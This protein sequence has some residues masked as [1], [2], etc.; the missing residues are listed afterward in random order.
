MRKRVC[1]VAK[2]PR[3]GRVK[4]RLCPPLAPQ[5]AAALASAFLVDTWASATADGRE[6]VLVLEG[7]VNDL[8][9]PLR[10]APRWPQ[11]EG[12]LGARMEAAAR[13]CLRDRDAAILIGTDAPGL[14][15]SLLAGAEAALERYDAVLG[16]ALDGG[17]YLLGLRTC[18][19]G[20]LADLPWSAPNTLEATEHRLGERGLA[21]ARLP[22]WF[23]VDDAPSLGLLQQALRADWVRAPATADALATTGTTA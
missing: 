3:P 2:A 12:D 23:D 19:P 1:V 15:P 17:Y 22:T 18:P 21:T 13:R 6:A 10:S 5:A 20:L 9:A 8:P 7:D 11:A 14:P 16:P 4:T